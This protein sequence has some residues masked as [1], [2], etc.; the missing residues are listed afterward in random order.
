MQCALDMYNE[1]LLYTEF[2]LRAQLIAQYIC[3]T[4]LL[5]VWRG[6]PHMVVLQLGPRSIQSFWW[7]WLRDL[8]MNSMARLL[9]SGDTTETASWFLGG[10]ERDSRPVK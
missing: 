3:I 8:L 10:G 2:H 4:Q 7:R 1:S 5:D 9:R 6:A